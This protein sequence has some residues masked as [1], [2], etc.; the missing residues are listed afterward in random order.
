MTT[1]ARPRAATAPNRTWPLYRQCSGIALD[2][3]SAR[4]RAWVSARRTILDVPTVTLPGDGTSHPILRGTIVDAPATARMLDRLLGHLLPRFGSRLIVLTTPV[5][6]GVTFRKEARTALEPL[7]P[8]TVLTVPSA[9]AVATAAGADLTRPLLVVDIGA[10]ITEVVLL[11]DGAVTDARHAVLG[12][13]DLDGLTPPTQI[14]DAV[15]AMVTTM[16]EE[17]HTAQTLDALQRG[18]LLAGGGALRPDI[19]YPLTARLH[20]PIKPVAAPHTAAVRGAAR[21]LEAA[22]T[23]PSTTATAELPGQTH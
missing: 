11:A 3:G 8:H 18:V 2:L 19:T 17:D 21:L 1:S 16:L 6:G 23:H 5:L 13:S 22:H 15:T 4:T 14:T 12:T 10:G 20:A 7:R 9:R